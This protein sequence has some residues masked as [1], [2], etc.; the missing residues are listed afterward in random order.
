MLLGWVL[1]LQPMVA[2]F[3]AAAVHP[4]AGTICQGATTPSGTG[5]LPGQHKDHG[6]CCPAGCPLAGADIPAPWPLPTPAILLADAVAG[7]VRA[8][9][10]WPARLGPQA[11][12][13]PPHEFSA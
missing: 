6:A 11:A 4:A 9:L 7:P 13:A 12:R 3:V 10:C 2:G 1:A 5:D 8:R